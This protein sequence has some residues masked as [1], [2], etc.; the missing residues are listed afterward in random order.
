[1]FNVSKLL[2][3]IKFVKTVNRIVILGANFSSKPFGY[4]P[5]Y[6]FCFPDCKFQHLTCAPMEWTYITFADMHK[7][8]A[9]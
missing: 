9:C 4:E 5:E 7:F 1:M 3:F 6:I 8:Y 2:D